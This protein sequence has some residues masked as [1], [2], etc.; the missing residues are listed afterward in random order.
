ML[1]FVSRIHR[2]VIARMHRTF[3]VTLLCGSGVAAVASM[4][5]GSDFLMRSAVIC[6]VL[7]GV[8]SLRDWLG[9]TLSP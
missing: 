5:L 1:Y 4:I 9:R 8:L 2:S 3:L 6:L 7:F